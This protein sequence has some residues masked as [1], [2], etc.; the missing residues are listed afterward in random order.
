[1]NRHRFGG[2]CLYELES[3]GVAAREHCP[4]VSCPACIPRRSFLGSKPTVTCHCGERFPAG[5]TLTKYAQGINEGT[6]K[7]FGIRK[8]RIRINKLRFVKFEKRMLTL[9]RQSFNVQ[10][11]GCAAI[12]SSGSAVHLKPAI[13]WATA[14]F[15]QAQKDVIGRS[16][17]C[18]V[19]ESG[20]LRELAVRRKLR[21]NV[22]FLPRL[23]G[24]PY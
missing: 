11:V 18:R 13:T 12:G 10:L 20:A 3:A 2:A 15:L 16:S 9:V 7:I 6:A 21:W 14:R 5:L 1:M 19:A 8:N 17:P 22:P 24:V 4:L 23:S